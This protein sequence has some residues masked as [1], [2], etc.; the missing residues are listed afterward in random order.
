MT[1]R[2]S[3]HLRT[4][5][6]VVGLLLLLVATAA[7]IA[8][9]VRP[10]AASVPLD[11]GIPNEQV[12]IARGL[13][14]VPG[15]D[16]PTAPI[17][18]DRVVTDGAA[19]YVQ[20]HFHTTAALGR[21][22]EVF[23]DL[24]DDTGARATGGGEASWGDGPRGPRGPLGWTRF[25][26]SWVPWRPPP[27]PLHGVVTLGP[28]P[29]TART[30]VLRFITGETVRVPLNLAALRQRRAYRGPLVQRAG[31][32]LR[33]AAARDTSLVLGFAPFGETRGVTLT[34]ARGRVAPLNTKGSGCGGSGF[35]DTGLACRQVWTYPPQSRGAQLML[36][37]RSFAATPN[38]AVSNAVGAGPW[39]LPVVIP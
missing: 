21:F 14:G 30:A 11:P 39:Q 25:L 16:Q 31:L 22:P 8:L 13:S 18:V 3:Q 34:D 1:P 32:Q 9:A 4:A 7:G 37:I 33:I 6:L 27:G 26:P 28:L 12:L 15:P 29:P 10:V 23:P 38:A 35:A 20:F 24:F 36:T 17:A 19:T 2:R 5:F